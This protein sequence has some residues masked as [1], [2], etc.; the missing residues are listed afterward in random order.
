[1]KP[2][3]LLD[4]DGVLADFPALY[5]E[6]ART[7]VD[8]ALPPYELQT[9]WRMHDALGLSERETKRVDARL[10]ES[11]VAQTIR[12]YPGVIDNVKALMQEAD[13]VFVT[14]PI[15]ISPTWCYDRT[16]W[17]VRHFGMYAGERVVHTYEKQYV[18]GNLFIDDKPSN[19]A[20]WLKHWAVRGGTVGVSRIALLWDWPFNSEENDP[21]TAGM[22]RSHDWDEVMSIVRNIGG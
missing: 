17:L 22:R 21:S 16:C 19:I 1:M 2:T 11:G 15:E 4:V 13:V 18:S 9:Q 14:S 5:R 3:L 6:L 20:K 8:R 10:L 7:V 12:P